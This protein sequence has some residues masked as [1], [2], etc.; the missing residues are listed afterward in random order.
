VFAVGLAA[1]HRAARRPLAHRASRAPWRCASAAGAPGRTV[2]RVRP[3]PPPPSCHP[4]RSIHHAASRSTSAE[5]VHHVYHARF[6]RS[7][8]RAVRVSRRRSAR[9]AS[10]ARTIH[11]RE[12]AA[13]SR[14]FAPARR[15]RSGRRL[16]SRQ[17]QSTTNMRF[18]DGR[19]LPC[20]VSGRSVPRG[21]QPRPLLARAGPSMP[22]TEVS[23]RC[24]GRA[25]R[26]RPG[27]T[28][29]RPRSSRSRPGWCQPRSR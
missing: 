14:P 4:C 3:R 6:R 20:P 11:Q 13:F 1:E 16:G 21:A 27:S 10:T 25:G 19:D 18:P 22:P 9:I 15:A 2:P 8:L 12:L 17:A 5:F 24:A 26:S 28:R 7:H 29:S 23:A